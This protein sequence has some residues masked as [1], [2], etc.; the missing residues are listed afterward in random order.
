[1][2]IEKKKV[3]FVIGSFHVG[4]AETQLSMLAMELVKR[5]RQVHLFC[6]ENDGPLRS[7]LDKAGVHT[8]VGR[9]DSNAPRWLKM[10]LLMRAQ[11]SLC[12][13]IFKHRPQVVHAF[14]PLTNFMGA[15]AGHIAGV[16]TVITS[17][18]ALGTHQ[19]RHRWWP[20]F[21]RLANR[22]STL[23]TGNSQ[24]VI[25]D[26]ARR[27]GLAREKMRII[28]NGLKLSGYDVFSADR[29]AIRSSLG[30]NEKHIG[31]V[32]VANLIP[33]KGHLELI[34]AFSLI[35]KNNPYVRLF[36]VGEDRG[37]GDSLKQYVERLGVGSSVSLLGRRD[38]VSRIL[39]AMDI[40]VMASHEEGC[41]NALLEKLAGGLPVAA[42]AVGGNPEAL[43][44]MP[45]CVLSK[46]RD[47]EALAAAIESLINNEN[48]PSIQARH[49]IDNILKR[50]SV[51]A[52]I[53]AHELLYWPEYEAHSADNRDEW[54]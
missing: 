30:L 52:M 4:G 49:R 51:S 3:L 38:D 8:H 44:D 12:T 24:A 11:I 34:E 9:Y 48:L 22:W 37:I 35:R 29:L 1:M 50:F 53:N 43:A 47:A 46:P 25:D 17:R 54:S 39:C 42:T 14:L 26:T 6:L 19:E 31:I 21:D 27:D 23:V 40:G 28:Y 2:T 5:G 20:L 36:L 15:F 10:L 32:Y 41:S 13:L 45:G 33:Y 7:S 18:R 16:E